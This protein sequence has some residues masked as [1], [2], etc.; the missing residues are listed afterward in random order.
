MTP[1]EG[2]RTAESIY[3]EF[4]VPVSRLC[5]RMFA[6]RES[7]EDAAQEIWHEIVRALP[8][9]EGRSKLSTWIWTIARRT[10]MRLAAREKT[11]SARFLR[12]LFQI[13]ENDGMAEI[14]R[15][16]SEDR[17]SW[18]RLQC[19]DCLS[20][21]MHC[22]S[23]EDRIVYLLRGLASL[24]FAEIAEIVERDGAAV[25]KAHSRAQA[26]VRRF[27]EGNCSLYNPDGNCRCKMSAPLREVDA[28]GEYRRV[29][30]LSSRIR[31][32]EAVEGFHPPKDYW[33][34]LIE[35]FK[36]S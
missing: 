33:K 26:K 1:E 18:I 15:V 24:P 32:L 5:R 21:I 35:E 28:K 14:E 6:R 19:D 11:Y 22:L 36:A 31:F 34:G 7:A 20:G 3:A 23:N 10:S 12:E 16:P 2:A 8:S 25:R 29:R 9:F 30:E 13:R 27:L 4:A 17:L